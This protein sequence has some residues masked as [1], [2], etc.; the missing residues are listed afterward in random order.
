ME[1]LENMQ[2]CGGCGTAY[3]KVE[4][5]PQPTPAPVQQT[6]QQQPVLQ[7]QYHQSQQQYNQSN[8]RNIINILKPLPPL[9]VVLAIFS[10]IISEIVF[11]GSFGTSH[12]G[13]WAGSLTMLFS[14]LC[15][16][17]FVVSIILASV[18]SVAQKKNGLLISKNTYFW[19]IIILNIIGLITCTIVFP[20]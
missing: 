14:F 13:G 5:V 2:F 3:R 15:V 9:L 4:T 20:L 11:S 19:S 16:L 17:F 18:R 10:R 12:Y 1:I 6:M 8:E 7:Q